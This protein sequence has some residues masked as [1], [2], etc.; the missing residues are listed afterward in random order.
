MPVIAA[1]GLGKAGT[2]RGIVS[3]ATTCVGAPRAWLRIPAYSLGVSMLVDAINNRKPSGASEST[4][5]GPFHVPDAPSNAALVQRVAD[6]CAQHHRPVATA[7]QARSILG[8]A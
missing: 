1:G 5:L 2:D 3:I 6:I 4:V 7:S 8:I